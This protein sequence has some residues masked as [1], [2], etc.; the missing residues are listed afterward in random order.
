VPDPV[1][2]SAIISKKHIFFVTDEREEKEIVL[3]PRRLRKIVVEPFA[4]Q[5]ERT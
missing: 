1:V 5:V 2:A 4:V 3:N